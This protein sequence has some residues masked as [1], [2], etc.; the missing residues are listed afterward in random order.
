MIRFHAHALRGCSRAIK[1]KVGG[2]PVF[3]LA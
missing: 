2:E 3:C 1:S